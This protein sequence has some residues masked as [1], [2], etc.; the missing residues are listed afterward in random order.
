VGTA[1]LAVCAGAL[2]G[3]GLVIFIAQNTQKVEVSF[4]W[5]QG[6]TPMAVAMLVSAVAGAATAVVVGTARIVQLRRAVRADHRP[7]RS[8]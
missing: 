3:I 4:L 8:P 2:L 7:N 6:T 1:W 5:M